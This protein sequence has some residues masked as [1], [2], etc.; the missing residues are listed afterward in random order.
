M[1]HSISEKEKRNKLV[2]FKKRAHLLKEQAL[3][4]FPSYTGNFNKLHLEKDSN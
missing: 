4:E 3:Y 2:I 1:L